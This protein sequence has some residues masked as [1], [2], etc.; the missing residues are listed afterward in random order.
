VFARVAMSRD[1]RPD[2]PADGVNC[3]PVAAACPECQRAARAWRRHVARTAL[4]AYTRLP[5]ELAE[6]VASMLYRA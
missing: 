5:I 2:A 4:A 3:W 6:K 1:A